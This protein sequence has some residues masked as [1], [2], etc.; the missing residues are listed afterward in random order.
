M[1][2]EASKTLIKFKGM[3]QI[4]SWRR[5]QHNSPFNRRAKANTAQPLWFWL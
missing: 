5:I 3:S 1:T 2:T 4:R